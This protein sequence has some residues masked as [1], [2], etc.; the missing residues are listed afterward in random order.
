MPQ[1]VAVGSR[2]RRDLEGPQVGLRR[3]RPHRRLH[4]HGRHDPD[5]PAAAACCGGS[6]R[7][8]A[9]YGLR[10]ANVFH[11]GDGNLHPLILYN[12]NE[13]GE[14]EKA[15]A[16]GAD[17][18][19]LCVEVGGCLTGEH[20]VGIE[21]RDLMSCS[22]STRPISSSRCASSSRF[23]PRW[24]LNPAKV[25][26]L[27]ER[28]GWR[29]AMT[30]VLRP[31]ERRPELA[32][33][34]R[35]AVSTRQSRCAIHGGGTRDIGRPRRGGAH[36]VDRGAD[37]H[38]ALRAG[39]TGAVGAGRHAAGRDRGGAR[40]E[41]PEPAFEPMDYR[42]LLGT[43]GEPTIGGLAATNVS[44]PRR[45]DAGACRDSLIGVRFVNG[46]GEAIKIG[47]PGDEERHR[48]DLVK[49]MAGSWGTLGILTEVTFKVLPQAE[50]E[51]TLVFEG[52]GDAR[53]VER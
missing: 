40:R 44:G 21:K 52:L 29:A 42:A 15:E 5:R 1:D 27:D 19:K 50:T 48:L 49:L 22:S 12:V 18:L 30:S 20:G 25:F 31:D 11:A 6:P 23:D 26:P 14:R 10:V 36:A 53:A 33:I 45:I 35:E 38:H 43:R 37:R 46:R 13:P 32:A 9:G 34:V 16:A 28:R 47:R 24:L 7:S 2:E 3:D 39:R 8:A 17:I 4:L 51:T 41:G